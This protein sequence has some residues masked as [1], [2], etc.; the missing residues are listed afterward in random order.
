ME[1]NGNKLINLKKKMIKKQD[2]KNFIHQHKC[3]LQL[4][5]S[6]NSSEKSN[7]KTMVENKNYFIIYVRVCEIL[8]FFY[9]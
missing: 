3:K 1:W 7:A 2:C 8:Q 6:K 9:A 5:R 4:G